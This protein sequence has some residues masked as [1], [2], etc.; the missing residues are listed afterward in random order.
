VG[1]SFEV[2]EKGK[3]IKNPQTGMMMELPGKVVGKVKI[4]F[5]GGEGAQNEYA[6]VSFT[7]GTIE[8]EK[9][10]SYYIREIK[11]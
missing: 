2:V 7:D 10:T 5:I 8:K 6:L 9:L 11:K 4:E 1:D 3:E